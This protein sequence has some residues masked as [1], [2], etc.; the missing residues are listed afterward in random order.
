MS[1]PAEGSSISLHLRAT[2]KILQ[3]VAFATKYVQS[4]EIRPVRG[5]KFNLQDRGDPRQG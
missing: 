2:K 5:L 4:D 3:D 1:T